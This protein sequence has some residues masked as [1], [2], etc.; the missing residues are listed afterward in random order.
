MEQKSPPMRCTLWMVLLLGCSERAIRFPGDLIPDGGT[1]DLP[2]LPT[3]ADLRSQA[4]ALLAAHR[5]CGVG[6]SGCTGWDYVDPHPEEV[7]GCGI[8]GIN[9]DPGAESRFVDLMNQWQLL[10]CGTVQ[11][12]GNPRTEMVC[13]NGICGG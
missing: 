6:P 4:L 10:R 7:W 9:D 12:P 2:S 5:K 3:C 13:V 1:D 8:V 11:C